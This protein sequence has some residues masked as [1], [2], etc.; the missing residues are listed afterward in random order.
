MLMN[1]HPQVLVPDGTTADGL[2]WQLRCPSC[3]ADT[4]DRADFAEDHRAVTVFPDRDD[5]DSPIGTRGGYVQV[6]L[7]CPVG[8]R[9]A[10]IVANHKGAEFVAVVPSSAG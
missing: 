4:V 1:P 2:Q 6:D 8:H 10:L 7:Q 9:F 5:Y 3:G